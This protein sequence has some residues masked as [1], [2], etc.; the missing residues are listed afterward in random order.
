M[1]SMRLDGDSVDVMPH[2]QLVAHLDKLEADNQKFLSDRMDIVFQ[3]FSSRI[4][5]SHKRFLDR[6]LESL[7][8]HLEQN[9]ENEVWQYSPDGLR[10]LL[11]TS[12]QVM[13]KNF[14]ATCNQVFAESAHD[15]TNVYGEVF[16]V[17]VENFKIAPPAS[18]EVPAP[19]SLGQ[20]IALDLQTSW[21]KGWW[22]RR[23]G[24]RQFADGFYELIEAETAPIVDEL[25]IRQAADIKKLALEELADFLAEQR[26]ILMDICEKSQIKLADLNG[27]FGI[28]AQ[29]EREELF[30]IIFEEL[31]VDGVDDADIDDEAA[32]TEGHAA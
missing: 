22:Q 14:T 6:A 17:A 10:M 8:Q 23:K 1:V 4:D 31:S 25:K 27:L 24:Y 19:V 26:G 28:T 20:T 16:S 3:Q 18:P 5:Q 29:E 11:R 21:W 7:M 15:L 13:K 30:D 2:D 12:Y 32:Q 9:G